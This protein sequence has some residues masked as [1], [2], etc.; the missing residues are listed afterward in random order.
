MRR[1]QTL[2]TLVLI[3]VVGSAGYLWSQIRTRVDL[4]VVPVTVHDGDGNLVAG[5]TL[6]DF[7][8]TEDGRPQSISTFS[9]EPQPL[10]AAIVVDDGMGGDALRRLA[11]LFAAVTAGFTPEDEM[12][13]FRY[14]HH[15]WKLSEFT[16][17]PHLIQKSFEVI[18][19]IAETRPAQGEPGDPLAGGPSV[20]SRILGL[21]SIGSNGPPPAVPS[22][23]DRPKPAPTSRLL[24]DAIYEAATALRDRPRD[25]RRLILI[26]SDGQVAGSNKQ[27]LE[28]NVDFLLRHDIQ[29]YAVATDYAILE[30]PT[31]VLNAYARAT[32]GDTFGG[33]SVS[34]MESAFSRITE[35]SRHQYILGYYSNNKVAGVMGVYREID[36]RSRVSGHRVTH[37]ISSFQASSPLPTGE[38]GPRSEGLQGRVRG[39]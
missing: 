34:S 6:D 31:S 22:G 26:I 4:V 24:H 33:G 1:K 35:Q 11:P 38:D 3:A 18:A 16:H 29:V 39:P 5:L 27:N 12:A 19:K 28:R 7:S 10:S 37:R 21:F 25:R 9:V 17:D 30:G 23:A 14:D 15:V 32:G 36:V 20:L 2:F 13:A 8:L